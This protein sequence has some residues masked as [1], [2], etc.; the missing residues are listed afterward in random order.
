MR[1]RLLTPVRLELKTAIEYYESEQSGLG[2]RLW[3]EIDQHLGWIQRNSEIP[4][5]RSGTY[6]RVNLRIFPYYIIYF[7]RAEEIIIAAIAHVHREPEY[8]IE[9]I[10]TN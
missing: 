3:N 8:W 5:L 2:K 1:V 6:R 10:T 7:I 4:R 9:R